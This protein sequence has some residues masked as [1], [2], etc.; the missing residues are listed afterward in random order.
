M[1]GRSNR[2]SKVCI[3]N[4]RAQQYAYSTVRSYV[5]R[6]KLSS[7]QALPN[8]TNTPENSNKILVILNIANLNFPEIY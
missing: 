3:G 8:Q 4:S 2:R 1:F 7:N 5:F 6:F